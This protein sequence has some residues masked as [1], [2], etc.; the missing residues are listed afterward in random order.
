M[1]TLWRL[2]KDFGDYASIHLGSRDGED[3]EPGDQADQAMGKR[4]E[5]EAQ[6]KPEV[7]TD[8]PLGHRR[9][10]SN[11]EQGAE[12]PTET[13]FNSPPPL[14]QASTSQDKQENACRTPK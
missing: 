7:S 9:E 11:S 2:Q 3:K 12:I 8:T 10:E 4:E 6:E 13:S 1:D 14:K 5:W